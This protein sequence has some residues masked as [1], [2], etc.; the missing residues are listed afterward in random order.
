MSCFWNTLSA[1]CSRFRIID[2]AMSD[3]LMKAVMCITFFSLTEHWQFV[4]KQIF[5]VKLLLND[6]VI[7][8]LL[9]TSISHCYR[10]RI[11]WDFSLSSSGWV[12]Y[13]VIYSTHDWLNWSISW[14]QQKLAHVVSHSSISLSA[15]RL[16]II[17]RL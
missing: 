2:T 12:S 8:W 15:C 14:F 10:A 3:K 13:V 16:C 7:E 11:Q 5:T 4:Q 6:E 9:W 17:S 1:E